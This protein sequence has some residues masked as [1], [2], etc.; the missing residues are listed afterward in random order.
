M[1]LPLIVLIGTPNPSMSLSRS[2][3]P[4]AEGGWSSPGLTQ[5]PYLD[6]SRSPS[7]KPNFRGGSSSGTGVSWEGARKKSQIVNGGYPAFSTQSNGFFTRH[8]RS[9]SSSLPKFNI[10]SYDHNYAEKE[11]LGRGRWSVNQNTKIGR[12]LNFIVQ[13]FQRY[14]IRSIILLTLIFATIL[15]WVTRKLCIAIRYKHKLT[16]NRSSALLLSQSAC[17]WWRKEIRHYLGS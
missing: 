2:P 3:S 14:R 10:T 11:K 13:T 4:S 6:H 9:I 16:N 1:T 8:M 17:S 5:Q 12:T 15:F 7:P